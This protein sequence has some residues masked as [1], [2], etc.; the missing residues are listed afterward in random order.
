MARSERVALQKKSPSGGNAQE[1]QG[2]PE[3]R[4]SVRAGLRSMSYDEQVAALSPSAPVQA[5]DGGAGAEGV[6]AAAARGTAGGGGAL[7]H[8]D[9]IQASFGRHDVSGV[10]AHTGGA[11]NEATSSMGAQAYATGNN[12]VLGG[13]GADLHTVAHEAAHVVQQRGGVSLSGGVGKSGDKYEQHADSV[14][15]A[16]VAGKSAEGLLDKHASSGSKGGGVQR[17]A[18]QLLPKPGVTDV[19]LGNIVRD[20]YKGANMPQPIGDGSTADAIREETKTN[21]QTHG[22]WHSQKGREYK[23]AL[24]KWVTANPTADAADKKAAQDIIA[25]LTDAIAKSPR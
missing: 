21:T 13:G 7:P 16:V 11:A 5:K 24:E 19:K 9:K 18:I 2:T 12:V 25:D 3:G 17:M 6:H 4:S 8:A 20:L 15:D 1:S 14:A 10:R 22:R 23:R